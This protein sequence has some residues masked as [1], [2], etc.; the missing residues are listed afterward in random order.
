M[1]RESGDTSIFKA[2]SARQAIRDRELLL[3]ALRSSDWIVCRAAK[4]LGI[5]RQTLN[6]TIKRMGIKKRRPSRAFFRE[7]A[8][9]AGMAPK[10]SKRVEEVA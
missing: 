2:V 8:R 1:W 10:K 7:R 9:V 5:S 3:T 6:K 4:L